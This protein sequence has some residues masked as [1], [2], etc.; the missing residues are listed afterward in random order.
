MFGDPR[1]KRREIG[2]RER[3]RVGRAGA[4]EA[5]ADNEDGERAATHVRPSVWKDRH[6]KKPG[7]RPL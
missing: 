4:S 7:L 1:L 5:Q 3:S 2:G 6:D